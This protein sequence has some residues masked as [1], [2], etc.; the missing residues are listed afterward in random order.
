[1]NDIPWHCGPPL[2]VEHGARVAAPRRDGEVRGAVKVLLRVV[3]LALLVDVL[4]ALVLT[5]LRAGNIVS[6]SWFATGAPWF[7]VMGLVAARSAAK[8]AALP[9]QDIIDFSPQQYGTR[10]RMALARSMLLACAVAA[11]LALGF[12]KLDHKLAVN[13]RTVL[14]PV[15]ACLF[16][17]ALY[18]M[19]DIFRS[20][21]GS[22]S[23]SGVTARVRAGE[24]V[25]S[26]LALIVYILT[27]LTLALAGLRVDGR[28]DVSWFLILAWP[29]II[30]SFW[31]VAAIGFSFLSAGWLAAA[32]RGDHIELD[33]VVRDIA[34]TQELH[35]SQRHRAGIVVLAVVCAIVLDLVV[36]GTFVSVF[37]AI[38]M[39]TAGHMS[40][41]LEAVFLPLIFDAFIVLVSTVVLDFILLPYLRHL[42]VRLPQEGIE[43]DAAGNSSTALK[44]NTCITC[45]SPVDRIISIHD[46]N[47]H[48]ESLDDS[49]ENADCAVCMIRPSDTIF[50]PCGHSGICHTCAK[51]WILGASQNLSVNEAIAQFSPLQTP[52]TL[53]RKSHNFF[54]EAGEL[55][56][57]KKSNQADDR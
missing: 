5:Y 57:H 20:H 50:L 17:L 15:E 11:S 12:A 22:G 48:V 38:K 6:W 23:A 49:L 34:G 42:F 29:I 8:W 10:P 32:C 40:K 13:V 55:P 51:H 52:L 3:N 44:L 1:M 7:V 26:R 36:I 14:G 27:L 31:A 41:H 47:V 56:L 39:L 24:N 4:L 9:P 35:I 18:T 45:R 2:D 46:P 53:L 19:Y 25:A 37:S 16:G 43:N 30:I 33:E 21:P 54:M 28:L